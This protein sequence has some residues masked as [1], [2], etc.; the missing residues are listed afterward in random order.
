MQLVQGVRSMV[1]AVCLVDDASPCTA[2]G[3]LRE[4]SGLPG[5]RVHRFRANAGI[6][7]SLNL[8]LGLARDAGAAWLL[9]VDQDTAVPATLVDELCALA[10]TAAE[11]GLP[12]GAVG[13]ATIAHGDTALAYPIREEHGFAV[14]EEIFQSGALWSVDA[15][16]RIG[17]FDEHLGIDAVDSAACLRLRRAG[18]AIALAP[19]VTGQ[20]A[21]GDAQPIR[22]LGRTVMATH[23]SP[24]RRESMT[25]NRLA[26]MGEEWQASPTHALRTMR[27]LGMSTLLAVT[28]EDD[29]WA[30]AKAAFRGLRPRGR[31]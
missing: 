11:H 17:G 15:L 7:R 27:R 14:T 21:Y 12:V 13:P 3:I 6:A 28:V 1:D 31:R 20:H 23:H 9:T 4:C 18:Y 25:R 16:T 30:S 2:D 10:S 8:G 5:V 24:Q 29:R 22:L 19:G 26:L